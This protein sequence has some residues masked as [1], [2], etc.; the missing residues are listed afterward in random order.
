MKYQMINEE[1][2]I[3][4]CSIAD[5]TVE[6]AKNFLKQCEPGASIG[7]LT[8][9]YDEESGLVVLNR[10]NKYYDYYKKFAETYLAIPDEETRKRLAG[11]LSE[12]L[13]NE[14]KVLENCITLRT[15]G[16]EVDRAL[17]NHIPEGI[18]YM[19]LREIYRRYDNSAVVATT[20][21]RYGVMVGKRIERAKRKR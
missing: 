8:L 7:T 1:L 20:A 4:S 3:A 12:L 6:Q 13:C 16:H 9:F 2:Q 17:K 15:V 18:H 21:F 11:K 5:L 10:D 14:K 19:V